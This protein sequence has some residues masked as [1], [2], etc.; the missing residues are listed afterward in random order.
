MPLNRKDPKV[1]D[2][3]GNRKIYDINQMSDTDLHN[4][5]ID[6]HNG[7]YKGSFIMFENE[8]LPLENFLTELFGE[9]HMK[10]MRATAKYKK[11]PHVE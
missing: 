1:Y 10:L 9:E 11:L 3:S 7:L 8:I 6:F 2:I 5:E 4:M